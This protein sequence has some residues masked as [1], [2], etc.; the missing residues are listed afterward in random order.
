MHTENDDDDGD[1]DGLLLV[2]DRPLVIAVYP[3]S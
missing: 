1:Y 3:S 2:V